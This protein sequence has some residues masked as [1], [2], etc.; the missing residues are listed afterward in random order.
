MASVSSGNVTVVVVVAVRVG[1]CGVIIAV[2]MAGD[3]IFMVE[4]RIL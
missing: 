2:V 4:L 3:G 1:S